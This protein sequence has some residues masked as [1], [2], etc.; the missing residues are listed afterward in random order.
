[1]TREE[2]TTKLD[3]LSREVYALGR[4]CTKHI[5]QPM[6]VLLGEMLKNTSFTMD[7]FFEQ[8]E[9]IEE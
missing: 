3:D 1:M 6:L 4:E 9:S 7:T 2:L 8:L 5:E